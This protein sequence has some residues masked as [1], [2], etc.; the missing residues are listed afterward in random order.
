MAY[1][2]RLLTRRIAYSRQWYVAFVNSG[3]NY[4]PNNEQLHK[5]SRKPE[6]LA[7]V[8]SVVS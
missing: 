2:R 3:Q 4:E 5:W 1:R 6:V 8:T 7:C